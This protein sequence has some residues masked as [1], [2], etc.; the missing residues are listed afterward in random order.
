MRK[1][2]IAGLALW[3]AFAAAEKVNAELSYPWCIIGD[4]RGF[5]CVFSS[6]E[7]CM[8]DARNRGFG[9]QCIKNLSAVADVLLTTP[10][11]A[12][13]HK[14]RHPAPQ[15]RQTARPQP[16]PKPTGDPLYES[17]E[18]PWKHPGVSCPGNSGEG[19]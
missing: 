10:A 1:S 19:G 13:K 12:A 14:V 3:A 9:G 15:A 4:T 11:Q 6:R 16:Q 7:Q 2:V 8:Q 17:C 5:E 18:Y